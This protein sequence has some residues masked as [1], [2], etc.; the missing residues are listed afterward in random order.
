MAPAKTQVHPSVNGA[1]AVVPDTRKDRLR[2]F[3]QRIWNDG[4]PAAIPEFLA[5][6]YTIHNDPGDPWHGQSLTQ[7]GFAERLVTSRAAAPDQIFV[8]EYMI[9]D[10]DQIAVAWNWHGTHMGDLPGI[11]ATGRDISM[12]GLTIYFFDKDDRLTGHWQVADRLG[13]Y[14]QLT[15]PRTG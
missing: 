3:I 11:P 14:Q 2:S 13:I 8:I 7:S 4:D 15:A 12:T 6:T 5:D 9:E 1:V 10:G